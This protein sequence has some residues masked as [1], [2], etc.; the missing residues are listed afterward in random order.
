MSDITTAPEPTPDAEVVGSAEEA[1]QRKKR[2]LIIAIAIVAVLLALLLG[3]LTWYL[4]TRKPISQI[5]VF[6]TAIPPS[7]SSTIYDV[8]KPLGVALDEKNNRMYI[9]QSSGARTVAVFDMEGNRKDDLVPTSKKGTAHL[10][11]Y[12]AVDPANGDVYVADRASAAMYVYDSTGKFLREF[13]PTGMTGWNPLGVT[14]GTNGNLFVS[15]ITEPTPRIWELNT[16]GTKVRELGQDDALT[17]PNGLGVQSDGSLIV[18]DSNTG[19]VLVYTDGNKSVGAIA[20]GDADAPIGLPRGVAV[21]DRGRVYV[22][23]TVNHVV[24][25]YEPGGDAAAPIPVYTFSFGEEG[26]VEGAFE[27]PNGVT[28][29]SY[30]RV[31]VTDRENNR[32]QVWSYQ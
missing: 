6:S 18:A 4:I 7:Y 3:A 28:T 15:D 11:V 2:G 1:P 20:R 13:T 21:D 22:V 19:R 30:G 27:F 10:P 16:D 32:V 14:F 17:F 25:V 31:Y 23:D 26:T 24:R 8:S 29:D 12:V 5:P 9:T